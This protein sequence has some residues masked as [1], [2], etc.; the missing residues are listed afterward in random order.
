M[1]YLFACLIA[2]IPWI[3][4]FILRKDLRREMLIMSLL[5]SPL[6]IFDLLYVPTYWIPQT[7]FGLPIGI[8]GI[9]FSF[10][11]GGIAAVSYAE[12]SQK[13]VQKINKNQR[14]FSIFVFAL[15]LPLVLLINYFAL[16][17]IAVAMYIALLVGIV[18]I[19][20]V[21]HDLLKASIIGGF[22]FGL[23]YSVAIILW[24]NIFPSGKDWFIL[25]GLP[26]I[27]FLNAPI[28]EIIFAIL[29]GAYW[30]CLY[31]L[32]FGYKFKK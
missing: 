28:Y 19:V 27:Y 24:I 14:H 32:I 30:G 20:M 10:L 6:G 8:E 25:E 5:A 21:R 15:V 1:E 13:K 9:I 31:E 7:L 12:I 3:I 16:F 26:R 29:F 4:F 11:I 2:F 22:I 23:I 18:L 17:N